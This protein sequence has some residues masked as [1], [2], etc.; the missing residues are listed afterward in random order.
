[1]SA[2]QQIMKQC[3]CGLAENGQQTF[4]C[5]QHF[6]KVAG[7][8][9]QFLKLP[10]GQ[11]LFYKGHYPYGVYRLCCGCVKV[12]SYSQPDI[13]ISPKDGRSLLI[14]CCNAIENKPYNCTVTILVPSVVEFIPNVLIS[15][16]IDTSGQQLKA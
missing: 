10:S 14:G 9:G 4:T 8:Q 13:E 7:Q 6:D 16:W 2:E 15:Q 12:Q 1:M 3:L 11:V 5:C